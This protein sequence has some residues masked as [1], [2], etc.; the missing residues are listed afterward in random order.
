[1]R[2]PS[3]V[4]RDAHL[5]TSG[6][7]S[8][9]SHALF[10]LGR[11]SSANKAYAF[12]FECAPDPVARVAANAGVARFKT[13]QRRYADLRKLRQFSLRHVQEPPRGGARLRRKR[14]R[15]A[16]HPAKIVELWS[17]RQP[18]LRAQ[19]NSRWARRRAHWR[20]YGPKA[21]LTTDG[22]S[23][24]PGAWAPSG[25]TYGSGH[26]RQVQNPLWLTVRPQELAAGSSMRA[27]SPQSGDSAPVPVSRWPPTEAFVAPPRIASTT[28]GERN[29]NL[30]TRVR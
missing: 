30:T 21:K 7:R 9:K 22:R 13:P 18:L 25:R 1:M 10:Q 8:V 15:V 29:A 14:A 28:A 6:T 5:S 26:A 2:L 19:S 23:A 17:D 11:A 16:F 12:P 3:H 27:C 20:A 4:A 24:R